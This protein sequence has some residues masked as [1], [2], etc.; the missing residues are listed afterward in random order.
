MRTEID[1][2]IE[3]CAAQEFKIQ[4]FEEKEQNRKMKKLIQDKLKKKMAQV[5]DM[6]FKHD[7]SDLEDESLDEV[8]LKTLQVERLQKKVKE[9][10]KTLDN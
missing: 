10:E 5:M 1:E 2:M 6:Q 3:K 9:L 7:D 4:K 8:T